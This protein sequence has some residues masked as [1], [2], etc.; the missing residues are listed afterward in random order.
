MAISKEGLQAGHSKMTYL[1]D[2]DSYPKAEVMKSLG[3]E[4]TPKEEIEYLFTECISCGIMI[5]NDGKPGHHWDNG[6]FIIIPMI[7]SDGSHKVMPH[8]DN[9]YAKGEWCFGGKDL[10][11]PSWRFKLWKW[12]MR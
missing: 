12:M 10:P 9:R 6:E 3:Y 5:R 11:L 4:I 2:P 1:A 8:G 7:H